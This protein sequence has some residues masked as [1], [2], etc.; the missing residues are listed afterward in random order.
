MAV[1]ETPLAAPVLRTGNRIA[2]LVRTLALKLEVSDPRAIVRVPAT[3][4]RSGPYFN[5]VS[6]G[7]P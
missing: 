1:P 2:R 5:R 6:P 4:L 7:V 3:G